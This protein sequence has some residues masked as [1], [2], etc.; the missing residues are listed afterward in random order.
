LV[1]VLAEVEKL[2]VVSGGTAGGR[3]GGRKEG[4]EGERPNG[5]GW[6]ALIEP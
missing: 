3:T 4:R 6:R 1:V 5:G 2:V